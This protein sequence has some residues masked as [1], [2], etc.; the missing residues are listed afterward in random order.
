MCSM[1]AMGSGSRR[2]PSHSSQALHGR[3]RANSWSWACDPENSFSSPQKVRSKHVSLRR[4]K[5]KDLS[6]SRMCAGSRIMCSSLPITRSPTSSCMNTTYLPCCAMPSRN[7]V[8]MLHFPWMW[9]L[10]LAMWIVQGN[11]TWQPCGHGTRKSTLCLWLVRRARMSVSW[12][13]KWMYLDQVHGMLWSSKIRHARSC[14]FR[15]STSRL[16]P[17]QSDSGSISPPPSQ[18]KIPTRLQKAKMHPRDC[19]QCQS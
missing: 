4:R 10:P 2:F 19:L 11:A 3:T 16:I 14:H 1:F 17:R 6:T 9:L 12:A 18:S 7:P 8:R 13:A 5:W 15:L